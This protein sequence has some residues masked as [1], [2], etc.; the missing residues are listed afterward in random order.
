MDE[1]ASEPRIALDNLPLILKLKMV[2]VSIEVFLATS[3]VNH[4]NLILF[5][6]KS[7]QKVSRLDVI[8]DQ[9]FGVNPFDSFQDLISN[10]QNCLESE[11]SL[12]V[13]QQLFKRRTVY[14]RHKGAIIILD[15]VPIQIRNA[16][17]TLDYS[18]KLRLSLKRR[19]LHVYLL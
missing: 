2:V 7:H 17:A 14:I 19:V 8:I 12:A 13:L 4:E 1:D 5:L 15:P 11:C 10:Q 16:Y 6:S 18:V 9:S 3:K